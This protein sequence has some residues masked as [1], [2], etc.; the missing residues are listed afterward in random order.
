VECACLVFAFQLL[1]PRSVFINRY[2]PPPP[3][4]WVCSVVG[5]SMC[6][7]NR[8]NHEDRV[9]NMAYGFHGEVYEKF[10]DPKFKDLE[11][12][13][14]IF[15]MFG[16]VFA[17]LP[18]ASIVQEKVCLNLLRAV[19]CGYQVLVWLPRLLCCLTACNL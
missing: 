8:G 6:W 2:V 14:R 1:Y 3:G 18:L 9:V 19:L 10:R 16:D 15:K 4:L 12:P 5:A 11:R 17:S 7:C 13:L